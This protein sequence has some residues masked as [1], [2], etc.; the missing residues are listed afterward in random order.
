MPIKPCRLKTG[1]TIGILSPSSK[2]PDEARF[3]KGVEYLKNLGFNVKIGANTL[4]QRGY[5][6]GTDKERAADLNEMFQNPDVQAIICSRGGYGAPRLLERIDFR[7]IQENPKIFV[8]YSDITVL[9]N[10]MLA[11]TGLVTYSGPMVAVEMGAG[12]HSFTEQNF[13]DLLK[14]ETPNFPLNNPHDRPWEVLHPGRAEG[15]LIGGCTSVLA[16]LAGSPYLP[17]FTNGILVIEDI[18][19][20]AYRLDRS[21]FHLRAAGLLNQLDAIVL[22]DFID[23]EAKDQSKPSLTVEEVLQDVLA[24]LDIPIIS[25]FAY[26]HG[27]IKH[28]VPFGARARLD[29][30]EMTFELIENAVS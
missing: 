7:A 30:N 22:G 15:T 18:D 2:P 29:T 5:L 13:W 10:A 26:G 24:G 28:T 16:P 1:D 21:L 19:E 25:G 9:Q 11:Q 27:P 14:N 20:E 12:I 3:L 4:K 6:A 23:C 17:D 8:G